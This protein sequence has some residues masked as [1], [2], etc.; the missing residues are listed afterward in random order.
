MSK[1]RFD[2]YWGKHGP[3]LEYHFCRGW[4][5]DAQGELSGCYGTNPDH[6]CTFEEGREQI[7]QWHE[8]EAA[9]W[10]SMTIE[11]WGHTDEP[12]DVDQCQ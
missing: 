12:A 8:T 7:A 10:R 4:T 9:R 3:S 11:Q 2:L 5:V 1:P 6:G